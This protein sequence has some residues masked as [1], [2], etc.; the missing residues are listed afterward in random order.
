MGKLPPR[1]LHLSYAARMRIAWSTDTL[2]LVESL[3]VPPS[4]VNRAVQAEGQR[5]VLPLED[6]DGYRVITEATGRLIEVWLLH[7]GD[8]WYQVIGAFEAGPGG[9]IRWASKQEGD[10]T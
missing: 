6:D 4:E 8:G 7:T 3:G 9:K 1:V 5:L 10:L 2:D